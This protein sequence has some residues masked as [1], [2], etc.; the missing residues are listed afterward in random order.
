MQQQSAGFA[1]SRGGQAL[2]FNDVQV[3]PPIMLGSPA[4]R[5]TPA[6]VL[7]PCTRLGRVVKEPIGRGNGCQWTRLGAWSDCTS[8][9]PKTDGHYTVRTNV[10]IQ[11]LGRDTVQIPSLI[12]TVTMTE[13]GDLSG[14]MVDL[15]DSM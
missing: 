15:V 6:L 8:V 3:Y 5:S 14:L 1:V 7:K 11:Q 10:T 2:L 9:Q 4:P 13:E 12:A